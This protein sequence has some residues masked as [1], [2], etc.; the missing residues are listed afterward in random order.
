VAKT[1]SAG[2]I[3]C[4]EH[5]AT[6]VLHCAIITRAGGHQRRTD[7][8]HR[9][10]TIRYFC[11]QVEKSIKTNQKNTSNIFAAWTHV[12]DAWEHT[13][14]STPKSWISR[15]KSVGDHSCAPSSSRPVVWQGDE[16]DSWQTSIHLFTVSSAMCR[17]VVHLP[18]TDMQRCIMRARAKDIYTWFRVDCFPT[19]VQP[20]FSKKTC[21]KIQNI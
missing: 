19:M 16:G 5:R 18:P 3:N 6:K 21:K 7:R 2:P 8:R 4:L 13:S 20:I 12:G 14:L 1:E 9:S 17:Y 15:M 10:I 11:L